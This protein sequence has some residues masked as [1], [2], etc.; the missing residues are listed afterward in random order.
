M[1]GV[2]K[3]GGGREG[4]VQEISRGC[5]TWSIWS[6]SGKGIHW[7]SSPGRCDLTHI[8][9]PPIPPQLGGEQTGG[10]RHGHG[11]KEHTEPVRFHLF[12]FQ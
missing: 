6:L 11:I 4:G 2:D 9:S 10:G 12:P 7:G 3:Q 1:A 5:R 8:P